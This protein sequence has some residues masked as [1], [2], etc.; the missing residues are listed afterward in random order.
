MPEVTRRRN[1]E[2]LRGLFQIL[3][4]HPEGLPARDALAKL[5]TRVE[6]TEYEKGRFE[7]GVPR[8]D[9]IVRFATVDASKAGWLLKQKGQWAVTDQGRAA[10]AQIPDP[11]AFYRRAAVLYREW[12]KRTPD[13][14]PE[15][16][17]GPA[18]SEAE[19]EVE[20]EKAP[21]ITLE[22]AQEQA[23]AEVEQYLRAMPP[24][25]F[26]DLVAS[27]LQAMGYHVSWVAPPGKDGGIDILACGD[28]LGTRPPRIKVQ[29]KRV[30]QNVTVDGLRAFMALLGDDEV[31]LFV[32]TSG[33]TKDAQDEART[34]ARRK[35][36]LVDL[37]R[38]FDLWIEHLD[39]LDEE[40]RRRFPLEP[41][42]FLAPE[43]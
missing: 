43:T 39:R 27:L 28:P 9:Q 22:Q 38:F 15:G 35:V 32:T 40:A 21:G 16:E 5:R 2:L 37:K 26:Q 20:V 3:L 11:E 13:V 6:P 18:G 4:E 14:S 17:P 8:F 36:T 24:Y 12:R 31:G 23:R 42:Y 41:I 34:Q 29:V 10:L 7:S 25:E 33:F 1:G 19:L 30:G